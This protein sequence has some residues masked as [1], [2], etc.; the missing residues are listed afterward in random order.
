MQ[1]T[2]TAAIDTE[3]IAWS[4]SNPRFPISNG[5]SGKHAQRHTNDSCSANFERSVTTYGTEV[6]AN[7]VAS[8]AELVMNVGRGHEAHGRQ[9]E[10]LVVD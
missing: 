2:M 1:L 6:F 9:N 8:C 4:V 7:D 10:V 5:K 3:S